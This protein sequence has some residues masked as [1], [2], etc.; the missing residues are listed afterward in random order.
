MG[1]FSRDLDEIR[2]KKAPREEG[3][4]QEKTATPKAL[5]AKHFDMMKKNQEGYCSWSAV[6]QGK[7]VRR[8]SPR[9]S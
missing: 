1:Y 7:S 5:G 6:S 4:R 2:N 9:G 3:S 8:R